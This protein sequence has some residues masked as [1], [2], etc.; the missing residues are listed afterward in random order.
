MLDDLGLEPTPLTWLRAPTTHTSK[1]STR[2]Q[3]D[4]EMETAKK[5]RYP[6]QLC[7]R[8]SDV[9]VLFVVHVSHLIAKPERVFRVPECRMPGSLAV[10][11]M[12]A[13]VETAS[14]WQRPIGL[15]QVRCSWHGWNWHVTRPS[16]ESVK[17]I[18]QASWAANEV[19]RP[20]A[21]APDRWVLLGANARVVYVAFS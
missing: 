12:P 15:R 21:G 6:T 4:A 3:L 16:S 19:A 20:R 2:S 11:K 14:M 10:S 1:T 13:W 7:P 8:I 9:T 5:L 18:G 17:L